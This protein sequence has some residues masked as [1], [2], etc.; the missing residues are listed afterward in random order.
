[1][2][3]FHPE[4]IFAGKAGACQSCASHET[5]IPARKCQTRVEV[6]DIDEHTSLIILFKAVKSFIAQAQEVLVLV[7]CRYASRIRMFEKSPGNE[8]SIDGRIILTI[9]IN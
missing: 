9:N 5:A 1:L 3:H 4:S 6:A 8:E 2:T 7:R